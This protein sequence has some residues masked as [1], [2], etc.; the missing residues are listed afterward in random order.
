MSG[1]DEHTKLLLHLSENVQDSSP[2]GHT[3][4]SG[5]VTF[6]PG[7]P[8]QGIN[9]ADFNGSTSNIIVPNSLDWYFGTGPFTIDFWFYFNTVSPNAQT[10]FLQYQN[11]NNYFMIRHRHDSYTVWHGLWFIC[12]IAGNLTLYMWDT[13]H[14]SLSAGQWYHL[15]F[16]QESST[17][18]VR[19]F[20]NGTQFTCTPYEGNRILENYPNFAGDINLGSNYDEATNGLNGSMSEVR[21][22]DI[23]RWT[24]NFTPPTSPYSSYNISGHVDEDCKII[25]INESDWSVEKT[26]DVTAGNYSVSTAQGTKLVLARKP[27]G[28]CAGF[29]G[30]TPD[31]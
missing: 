15:A 16:V 5:N 3:I 25:L 13:V 20:L 21:I 26:Q 17:Q 8:F 9:K 10:L 4:T 19:T 30:V 28:E 1:L 14:D 12:K 22:S 29:S 11:S 6:S 23:A 27:D 7:G 18:N 2:S 24:E 31:I